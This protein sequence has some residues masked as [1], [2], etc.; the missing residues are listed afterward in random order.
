M[1]P[2]PYMVGA[3][4]LLVGLPPGVGD[5]ACLQII[6]WAILLEKKLDAAALSVYFN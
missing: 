6:M 3:R 1:G 5:A 2:P 4:W